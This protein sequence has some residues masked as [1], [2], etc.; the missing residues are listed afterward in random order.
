VTELDAS[1]GGLLGVECLTSLEDLAVTGDLS[2]EDVSRLAALKSLTSMAWSEMTTITPLTNLPS[3][4]RVTLISSLLQDLSPL[5]ELV[6]LEELRIYATSSL[7]SLSPIGDLRQLRLLQL[8]N[9]HLGD[10]DEPDYSFLEEL[11][12]E[13]LDLSQADGLLD[14]TNVSSTRL[15]QIV[16]NGVESVHLE[17]LGPPA[18]AP[19]SI[20]FGLGSEGSNLDLLVDTLCPLDWCIETLATETDSPHRL[21]HCP[22]GCGLP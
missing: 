9:V 3:L 15:N 2:E 13:T 16:L 1:D 5:R 11:D 20:V 6:V 12:L 10:G 7:D 14:F 21:A 22:S 17:R 4:H 19:G 8:F 18:N